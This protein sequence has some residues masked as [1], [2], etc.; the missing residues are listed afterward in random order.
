M[1]PE[2]PRDS[3][4]GVRLAAG[5]LSLLIALWATWTTWGRSEWLVGDGRLTWRRRFASWQREQPFHNA[6]IELLHQVDSDGDDRFT[7]SVGGASGRCKVCTALH[8]PAEL[9]SLAEWL[10]A[11]TR[12]PI[13]RPST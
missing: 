2:H 10:S 12:F 1:P 13:E 5:A 7:L 11:R 3:L 9:A 4:T 6:A 8:D